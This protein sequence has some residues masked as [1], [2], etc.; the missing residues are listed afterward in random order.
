VIF[1]VFEM[2]KY[3]NRINLYLSR[4][5]INLRER[6]LS[7]R[8]NPDNSSKTFKD[9]SDILTEI[10]QIV[11]KANLER[12]KQFHYLNYVVSNLD[13]GVITLYS[14]GK[15][16]L[17]NP[18]ALHV[19]G[20]QKLSHISELDTI[21]PGFRQFIESLKGGQQR[22]MRVNI[23][24]KVKNLSFRC[25]EF[26]IQTVE[27]KLVSFLDIHTELEENELDAW[28][29]LI[30][31]LTHEIMNSITPV[32]TLAQSM[33]RQIRKDNRVIE[34]NELDNEKLAELMDGL[35]MIEERGTG[36]LEFVEKFRSLTRIPMPATPRTAHLQIGPT[37]SS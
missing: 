30:R 27:M 5:L 34:A 24:N 29:K 35:E 11:F 15:T 1:Q 7:F 13:V 28:Q 23:G 31:V 19:L 9:L 17:C 32:N 18:A 26:R 8:L 12:E 10:Q 4:F 33:I 37:L 22:M 3:Q 25:G 16:E 21:S 36:V 14:S 2:V 6:S 20:L